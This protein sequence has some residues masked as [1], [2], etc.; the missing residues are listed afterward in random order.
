MNSNVF[1]TDDEKKKAAELHKRIR[2]RERS[3]IKKVLD[4]SEG[5]RFIWRILSEAG[6]YRSCFSTNALEMARLEG[7]RDMGNF[8]IQDV[9]SAK[10]DALEIMRRE[11]INDKWL[12]SDS[13]TAEGN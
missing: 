10:P 12:N 13:G 2:D 11:A 3:D 4:R 6:I 5:R 1:E 9:L 8:I 7:K